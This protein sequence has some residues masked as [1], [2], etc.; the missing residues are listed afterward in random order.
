M[1]ER[2]KGRTPEP[3]PEPLNAAE[4]FVADWRA[5]QERMNTVTYTPAPW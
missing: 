5:K 1:R 4:R 2:R 3:D